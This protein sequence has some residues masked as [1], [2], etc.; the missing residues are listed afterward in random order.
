MKK[1][2]TPVVSRALLISLLALAVMAFAGASGAGPLGLIVASE[3]PVV[4]ESECPDEG[5]EV[6]VEDP[7]ADPDD[8]TEGEDPEGE[9]PEGE[10]PEGEDPE[11]EDPEGDAEE[12]E[13]EE[14]P[15]VEEPAEEPADE[16]VY[17]EGREGDCYEAAGL[18]DT[19][20]D[21]E[22]SVDESYGDVVAPFGQKHS[23]EVLL[24]NC[25]KNPQAPGLLRALEVHQMHLER[26][27]AR[28]E[29]RAEREAAKAERAAARDAA[30]AERAAARE[31]AKAARA[32]AKAAGGHG[33]GHGH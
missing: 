27:E 23:M 26:W 12:C 2:R 4:V 20:E 31:A 21:G 10:D 7:D 24:A 33:K 30:K 6:V 5:D 29:M 28:A 8:G 22:F 1:T 3:D 25:Q 32:A 15:T 17:P 18:V 11:G 14:E 19:D 16:V 13:A 9:D